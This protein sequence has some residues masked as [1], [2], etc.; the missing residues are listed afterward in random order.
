MPESAEKPSLHSY[1]RERYGNSSQKLVLEHK[2]S[3]HRRV[4]CKNHHIF[5][6]RCRDEGV[7]LMSLQ[8]KPP[9]KTREGYRITEQ[10]GRAFLSARICK[11]YRSRC[12]LSSK[13]RTLQSWLQSKVLM[14]DYQKVTTLSYAKTENTH[15]K[16]KLNQTKKAGEAHG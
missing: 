6:M 3:L 8:I 9:M 13:I 4:R 12:E 11:T 1:L 14:E 10:A 16:T 5:N 15:T 2:R 7:I